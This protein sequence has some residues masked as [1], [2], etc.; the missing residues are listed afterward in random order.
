MKVELIQVM[1]E[2]ARGSLAGEMT[3]PEVVSR[4]AA[5][6]VER[7][8]ADYSRQ[9]ITYYLADG[10]SHVVAAPHAPHAIG[11]TFL[12][13]AVESAVRQSQRNEHSYV[14]FVR[15]TMEAGCI[16]YFVQITGRRAIYFGRNGDNHVEHFP[17]APVVT[18]RK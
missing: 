16:G 8:H 6:G 11:T 2:C 3:F 14:D 10:D 5:I 7:Y 17:L 15:K 13:S 1:Q 12:S 9:E 4:L 18:P